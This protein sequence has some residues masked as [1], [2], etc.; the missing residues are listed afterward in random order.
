MCINHPRGDSFRKQR[1]GQCEKA[2]EF[3]IV[4]YLLNLPTRFEERPRD[5]NNR[6]GAET[7][8]SNP[9]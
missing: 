4:K 3:Q 7:S 5:S 2:L 8:E 1:E 6:G 9:E